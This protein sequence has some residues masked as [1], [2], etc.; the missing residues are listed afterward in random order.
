MQSW[1]FNSTAQGI[2]REAIAKSLKIPYTD[3][4]KTVRDTRS[5]FIQTKDGKVYELILK[6][7]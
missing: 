5:N 3:V 1:K 2:L 4:Y 6:E 7:V